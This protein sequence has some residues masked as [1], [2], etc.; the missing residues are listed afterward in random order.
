LKTLNNDSLK[1]PVTHRFVVPKPP[2]K[3]FNAAEIS[4][5]DPQTGKFKKLVLPG[6]FIFINMDQTNAQPLIEKV[7]RFEISYTNRQFGF[8]CIGVPAL[9]CFTRAAIR[10]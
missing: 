7:R 6:N 3:T 9:E 8:D 4:N 5:F 1:Q 10:K 2:L